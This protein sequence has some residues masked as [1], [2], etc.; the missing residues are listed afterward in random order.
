[1][2]RL[3]AGH[4][5]H[6]VAGFVRVLRELDGLLDLLWGH[7]EATSA[8]KTRQLKFSRLPFLSPFTG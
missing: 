4:S 2:F 6:G 5:H 8:K 7:F 3:G 1:M